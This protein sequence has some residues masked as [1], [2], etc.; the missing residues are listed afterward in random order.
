MSRNSSI[1]SFLLIIILFSVLSN[2]ITAQNNVTI[3]GFIT[4]NISGDPL[5]G[6]NILLYKDSI[7]TDTPPFRG[8]SSNRYGFYAI[9]KIIKGKYIIVFRNI[10][11]RTEIKDLNI[12]ITS[13]TLSLNIG[14]IPEEVRLEEVVVS[15]TRDKEIG[16][17]SVDVSP[18]LLK[19]LPSV[20]G[21]LDLFKSLQMVPGVK[22]ANELSSGLYIRGGSPDQTLTL[23]DGVILYN[24][25]HLGNFASTFNTNAT[26]DIRLIKGAFPAEY[27]GRLSSVLDIK[28]RSGTK[29]KNKRKIG[30][31]LVNSYVMLE[32]PIKEKTTYMVFG[33][34]MYYDQLQKKFDKNS[35]IPR[36]NFNDV[37]AKI[38]YSFSESNI[39]SLSGMLT[40]DN[41]Y[42]P[43]TSNDILYDI[44][45]ENKNIS[46]NWLK[47]STNSLLL[48]NSVSYVNYK[49][50][51]LLQDVSKFGNPSDYFSSSNLDDILIKSNAELNWDE[52]NRL[53]VGAELALH[54]Y[55]LIYT[56]DYDPNLPLDPNTNTEITALEFST[57]IQNEWNISQ[58]LATNV[59]GRFYYFKNR[60]YFKIEPRVSVSYNVNDYFSLKAAYADAHQFLHLIVRNDIT[61]PT[62]LWYPSSS[63][64][65]PGKSSQYVFGLESEFDRKIYFASIEAYYK[66][67]NN[68]Y[69]YND[70][71][72]T[73][74]NENIEN[75]FT[76]GEGEAYGL[77]FFVNKR[78]GNLT[79]WF[80]YTLSW[81]KR[82]FDDLNAGRIFFPRYDRRH[83]ISI[84]LSYKLHSQINLSATWIY[85]TGQGYTVPVGQY[86][87]STPV[88]GNEKKL[89][90]DYSQRNTFRM[91]AYHKL[92][93]S[94]NYEFNW[95]TLPLQAY[96]NLLNVYNQKNA[97]AYYI[98]ARDEEDSLQDN[99]KMKQIVLFPFLPSIGI[100]F[101]F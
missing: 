16:P 2:I 64:I 31:G 85:S 75:N 9:P 59:G 42:N 40:E 92:D 14:M 23:V 69:E 99:V 41:L 11:F 55:N 48:T 20:S 89:L 37:N 60:K 29:E 57:F 65:N 19:M 43:S 62:D 12:T 93:L 24:P 38:T 27:G 76:E 7:S 73:S 54:Q 96:L 10:G 98:S 28:L 44:G 74:D 30:L 58:N 101:E 34:M 8:A 15:E 66:I 91:P 80:G 77:E 88:L 82:K 45:W 5:I 70:A 22:T 47:I 4:D 68:L 94:L 36:Y 95:G 3:S 97:F 90:Y 35:I 78:A 63:N 61:L 83:D 17:S 87:F 84:V 50:N 18:E 79:G 100:T 56:D 26:Q 67:I 71:N 1:S 81:T 6:S 32:G 25:T 86:S 13:G 49:F 72:I 39:V 51:S 52:N 33:R 46:L 21:E 53:K